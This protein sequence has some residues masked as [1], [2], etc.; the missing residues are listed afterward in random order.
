M[1]MTMMMRT[2]EVIINKNE[3]SSV[4]LVIKASNCN[5]RLYWVPLPESV[6]FTM[7]IPWA[8]ESAGIHT[9]RAKRLAH[10]ILRFKLDLRWALALVATD[11]AP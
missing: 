6:T 2:K 4:I 5:D 1:D 9:K 11:P 8:Q 7:G 3:G 10:K